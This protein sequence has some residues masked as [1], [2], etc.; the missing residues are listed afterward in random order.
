MCTRMPI[1]PIPS[2]SCESS[3]DILLKPQLNLQYGGACVC[4]PPIPVPATVHGGWRCCWPGR[5]CWLR[6]RGEATKT[7]TDLEATKAKANSDPDPTEDQTPARRKGSW[8]PGSWMARRWAFFG[9]TFVWKCSRFIFRSPLHTFL[10]LLPNL[11]HKLFAYFRVIGN[12]MFSRTVGV[13]TSVVC[14]ECLCVCC[15]FKGVKVQIYL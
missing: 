8:D 5:R 3:H 10:A 13:F 6:G 4:P 7:P 11:S 2:N 15:A 1:W 12:T 14:P 9:F